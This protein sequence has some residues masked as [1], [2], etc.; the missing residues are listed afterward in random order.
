ML[1]RDRE[2]LI[3]VARVNRVLGAAT[4][5]L[6][7][8]RRGGELPAEGLRS[9]GGHLAELGRALVERADEIDGRATRAE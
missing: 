7:D 4:V 1:G 6:L 5:E 9:M 2:L 3:R 8:N